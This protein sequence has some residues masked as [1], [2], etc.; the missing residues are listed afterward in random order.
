MTKSRRRLACSAGT[1]GAHALADTSRAA[2]RRPVALAL[3]IGMLAAAGTVTAQ[4][5]LTL[6][7]AREYSERGDR[8]FGDARYREAFDAY[9]QALGASDSEL[10][11]S[12][13]KGKIRSALRLSSFQIAR[14]EADALRAL[15]DTDL[16]SLTLYADALWAAGVFDE[17]DKAY[18]YALEQ[19]P[20]SPRAR[21]G[22]ARSLVTRGRLEEALVE[23][24]AA[25]E[26]SPND[27]E[28]LVLLGELYERLH[29]FED[30]ARVYEAYIALL[31]PRLRNETDVAALKVKLLRSFSGRAPVALEESVPLHTVPFTLRN[32]KI[33]IDGVLNG[34]KVEFVL[35][36]GAERT[37]I[38]R[39][40][41]NRVGIRGIVE[42][43]ITGVG[44]PGLRKLSVARADTLTI[45]TLTVRDFPVSIR[46]EDMP[47]VPRWH[48]EMFSPM[49]LGLSAVVDYERREVTLGRQI[50]DG[51]ADFRLPMR[52]YRLPMVRGVLNDTHSAYFVVDTAGELMSIS[53][54]VASQLEPTL[55]PRR[56]IGIKVWGVAGLDPDAFLLTG[57]NLDFDEIEYRQQG[58]A[59]LNLRAP[60]VLLGFQVGGILGHRFLAG[61]KVA[62]DVA[63]GELRLQRF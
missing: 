37:A 6:D 49:A 26:G 28:I 52:V 45:G 34:H 14:Q 58:V 2:S 46:R 12:A 29:R 11:I 59:V 36:T 38:S 18:E 3:A 22:V 25:L 16:D 23:T 31:P 47:G 50:P 62:M 63:R 27:S 15:T 19:F 24:R 42:T 61:Y 35:D 1:I 9:D 39:D 41:A 7:K 60:S 30:A 20:Q 44:A 17:S 32:K 21:F 51:P 54:D 53:R 57:I 10:S 5:P 13:R 4:R 43:M 40:T 8:M 48:N 55:T 56:R 33:I